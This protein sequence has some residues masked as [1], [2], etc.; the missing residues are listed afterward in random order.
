MTVIIYT[1]VAYICL[2]L[3]EYFVWS[4][5]SAY[6][7]APISSVLFIILALVY[8]QIIENNRWTAVVLPNIIFSLFMLYSMLNATSGHKMLGYERLLT[9]WFSLVTPSLLL[10]AICFTIFYRKKT[11]KEI[12]REKSGFKG[13]D[14][15]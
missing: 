15:A 10:G 3:P 13:I 12:L 6:I 14:N 8:M 9:L 1:L 7:S 4:G 2:I 5:T 11:R